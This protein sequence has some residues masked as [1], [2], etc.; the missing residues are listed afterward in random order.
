MEISNWTNEQIKRWLDDIRETLRQNPQNLKYTDDEINEMI[1]DGMFE[2]FTNG[3]LRRTDLAR[4]ANILGYEVS[5]E[6]M[7][8]PHPDP[9]DEK[10][11]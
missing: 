7:N 6:F 10:N 5:E 2:G 11:K 4:I 1:L 8:D 3:E 9:I